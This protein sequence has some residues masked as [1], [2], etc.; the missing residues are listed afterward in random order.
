MESNQ[1]SR[2]NLKRKMISEDSDSDSDSGK[3]TAEKRV[4][5]PKGRRRGW[6]MKRAREATEPEKS[7]QVWGGWDWRR[8]VQGGSFIRGIGL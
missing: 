2:S 6:E 5:F 7:R 4:R 8:C 3:P 1:P